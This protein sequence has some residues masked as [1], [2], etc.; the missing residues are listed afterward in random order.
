MKIKRTRVAVPMAIAAAL[1][2]V[3]LL[4]GCANV[5]D[6]VGS[7]VSGAVQDAT[8]GAVTVGS[9]PEGWP[10]EVPVIEGDIVGGGK[11]PDGT[12]GWV[13]VIKSTAADPVVD[14]Q[15]QLEAAGF[16]APKDFVPE[17]LPEV[18]G[19]T[20]ASYFAQNDNY[21]VMVVG[22]EQGLLYTVVPR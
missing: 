17:E 5:N 4:A 12:A 6:A 3:P 16:E 18:D 1:L 15:A 14:A 7:A 22:S 2:S 11:N 9:M 21:V 8:G 19:I 10:T 20:G 13:V